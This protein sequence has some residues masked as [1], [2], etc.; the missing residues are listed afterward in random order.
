MEKTL[1]TLRGLRFSFLSI[2][3][4]SK[5]GV[6]D[7]TFSEDVKI[8]FSIKVS[9][10]MSKRGPDIMILFQH[11]TSNSTSFGDILSKPTDELLFNVLKILETLSLVA[12][13]NLNFSSLGGMLDLIDWILG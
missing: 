2:S 11:L 7:A 12:L 3:T 6:T 10:M 5:T 9:F 1:S 4:F 8:A 13:W